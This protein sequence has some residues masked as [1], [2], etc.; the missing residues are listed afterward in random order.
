MFW[1]S[2]AAGSEVR[3]SAGVNDNNIW[4]H[5]ALIPMLLTGSL[6][7]HSDGPHVVVESSY[8]MKHDSANF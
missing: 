6:P 8:E 7:R 1:N 2:A 5:A 3:S 4:K